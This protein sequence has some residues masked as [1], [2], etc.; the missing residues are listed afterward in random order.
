MNEDE[1]RETAALLENAKA[2]L[3]ALGRQQEIIRLT[4]GEHKRARDT[5]AKMADAEPGEEVLIPVGA[6]VFVYARVSENKNA[7]LPA[8]ADVSFQRDPEEA[9]KALDDRMDELNRAM[10]K[11]SERAAQTEAA[12]QQLSEKLQQFYSQAG[13]Q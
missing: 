7:V 2:Q 13:E 11:V 3:E 5:V 1:A 4:I 8:G 12:M 6:E 9:R 10:N